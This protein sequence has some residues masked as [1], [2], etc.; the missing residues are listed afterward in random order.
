MT[1]S[2]FLNFS[3][4]NELQVG[5]H[6]MIKN[7]PCKIIEKNVS[8]TGKHG[9]AKAHVT[10]KDIFTDKKYIEIFGS[11]DKV[12]VPIIMRPTYIV[13]FTEENQEDTNFANI[14]VMEESQVRFLPIQVNKN[15]DDDME[16]LNKIN[17]IL[18]SDSD[19]D[20]LVSVIQA[21]GKERIT[22][23]A[24]KAKTK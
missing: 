23:C 1:D 8:K 7:Y 2:E 13:Q 19:E 5:A 4:M 16:I 20:C 15:N 3:S 9:S 12:Q 22:Q 11:A 6:M 24:T 17:E 14:F 18:N 21:I 10:G